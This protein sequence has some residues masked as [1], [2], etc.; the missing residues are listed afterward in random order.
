MLTQLTSSF[1]HPGSAGSAFP[2]IGAGG[3]TAGPRL[4]PVFPAV[5][6]RARTFSISVR[7]SSST[8]SSETDGNRSED[9]DFASLKVSFPDSLDR[10]RRGLAGRVVRTQID[11]QV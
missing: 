8:T 1:C 9:I 10:M 5:P 3:G 4:L 11:C 6:R 7:S 2:T